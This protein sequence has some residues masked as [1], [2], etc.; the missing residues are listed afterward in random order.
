MDRIFFCKEFNKGIEIDND[1]M[2]LLDFL[3]KRAFEFDLNK[4]SKGEFNVT[5]LSKVFD[6]TETIDRINWLK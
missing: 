5:Q 1:K 3:N 6:T 4:L 2:Y